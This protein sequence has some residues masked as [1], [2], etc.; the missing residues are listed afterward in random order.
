M[1]D[2]SPVRQGART[3][4]AALPHPCFGP[5]R[6]GARAVAPKVRLWRNDWDRSDRGLSSGR[7]ATVLQS[8][9]RIQ[10][11]SRNH[12][13]F[14][15]DALAPREPSIHGPR[16]MATVAASSLA[17]RSSQPRRA[18]KVKSDWDAWCARSLASTR[19]SSALLPSPVVAR[20]RRNA[21][22]GSNRSRRC[23]QPQRTRRP[24]KGSLLDGAR[25]IKTLDRQTCDQHLGSGQAPSAC[26][27]TGRAGPALHHE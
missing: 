3:H 18:R 4:G 27:V 17:H 24:D 12:A 6:Q 16:P 5:E 2:I 9:R 26:A 11:R 8:R 20:I 15:R 14:N 1:T 21:L 10:G 22:S 25:P 7:A 19:T 13:S 23:W